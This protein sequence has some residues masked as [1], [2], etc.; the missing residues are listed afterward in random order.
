MLAEHVHVDRPN[1]ILDFDYLVFGPSVQELKYIIITKY[2][3]SSFSWLAPVATAKSDHATNELDKSR[4]SFYPTGTW[5]SDQGADFKSRTLATLPAR[6]KI[7][8]RLT[9]A[10]SL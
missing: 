4:H 7:K 2:G 6:H 8:H 10:C 9:V 1:A 5:V 3:L